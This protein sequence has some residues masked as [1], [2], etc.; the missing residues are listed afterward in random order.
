[1]LRSPGVPCEAAESIGRGQ[2]RL[3]AWFKCLIVFYLVLTTLVDTNPVDG[4]QVDIAFYW[5]VVLP[6]AIFTI[7]A[8]MP[9]LRKVA[10]PEGSLELILYAV[11]AAG[12]A[13]LKGEWRLAVRVAFLA[14]PLWTVYVLKIRVSLRFLNTFSLAALFLCAAAFHLGMN[15]FGYLPGQNSYATT[16]GVWWRVSLFPYLGPPV[17]GLI[18]LLVFLSNLNYQK[19][20]CARLGWC[21][22]GTYFC[23]FS[24]SRTAISCMAAIIVIYLLHKLKVPRWPYVALPVLLLSY[25][26]L[27]VTKYAAEVISV[28]NELV[29]S[30]LFRTSL[31]PESYQLG[32]DSD[33]LPVWVRQL[34]V[35][36]EHPVTGAG[37]AIDVSTSDVYLPNTETLA[38]KLL[39][40]DGIA[41]VLVTVFFLHLAL[42]ASKKR[43][44]YVYS[45]ALI[46]L[47]YLLTY[48]SFLVPYCF[49][50]LILAAATNGLSQEPL[51]SRRNVPRQRWVTAE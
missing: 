44:V 27:V 1:M 9:V 51:V 2:R 46:W 18:G 47:F 19:N 6:A 20:N 15:P 41:G 48:S 33:R 26:G 28:D 35:F 22:L 29:N 24:G 43:D 25:V 14:L 32:G 34:E 16:S 50:Y 36:A 49:A 3:R 30:I 23:V 31:R 42:I 40:R 17:S 21:A 45:I 11:V 12:A 4:S 5:A 37:D 39:A 13:T 7:G 38:T 8:L 10:W